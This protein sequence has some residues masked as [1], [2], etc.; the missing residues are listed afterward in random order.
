MWMKFIPH[1]TMCPSI[2]VSKFGSQWVSKTKLKC[3]NIN[4]ILDTLPSRNKMKKK[5]LCYKNK[6]NL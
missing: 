2:I 6:K 1:L 3:I 5:S 4:M